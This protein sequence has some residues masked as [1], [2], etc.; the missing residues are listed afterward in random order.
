MSKEQKVQLPEDYVAP[1]IEGMYDINEEHPDGIIF[2]YVGGCDW[3]DSFERCLKEFILTIFHEI[4]HVL[5]PDMGDYVPVAER[6][7]ADILEENQQQS[8]A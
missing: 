8:G 2:I 1:P 5:C 6:I 4:M 7:L 3:H